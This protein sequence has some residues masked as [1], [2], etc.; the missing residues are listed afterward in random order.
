M[1]SG[2][3]ME[4]TLGLDSGEPT[5]DEN[6]ERNQRNKEKVTIKNQNWRWANCAAF[7]NFYKSD[8]GKTENKIFFCLL[9]FTGYNRYFWQRMRK[10]CNALVHS[11]L[12]GKSWTQKIK[13]IQRPLATKTTSM[14]NPGEIMINWQINVNIFL[15]FLQTNKR[16]GGEH[17]KRK[18]NNQL[19]SAITIWRER[20]SHILDWLSQKRTPF[21]I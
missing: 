3:G 17:I 5:K 11:H 4:I 6:W 21:L 20:N 2:L 9:C 15:F 16:R 10:H 7:Q 1:L 18:T 13:W 12:K 8:D 19:C 14:P